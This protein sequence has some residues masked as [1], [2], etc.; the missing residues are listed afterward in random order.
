[1]WVTEPPGFNFYF[2]F[3]S[4]PPY[5]LP[6]QTSND[7]TV[8]AGD[9][10]DLMCNATGKPHPTIVW[11]RL[12]GALLPIGREKYYVSASFLEIELIN[13]QGVLVPI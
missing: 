12:G 6:E 10:V 13:T 4:V 1:M 8:R 5:L 2:V 11:T 7:M 3:I 9:N